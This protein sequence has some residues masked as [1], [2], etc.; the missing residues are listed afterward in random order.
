MKSLRSSKTFLSITLLLGAG[1]LAWGSWQLL[2]DG[3]EQ[4]TND[5]FVHADFTLVAPKVPGFVRE[6]QV[7][8]NQVVKAGQLLARIDDRDYRTA[9]ASARAEVASAE[10]QLANA[11]A[12]LERQQSQIGRAH[13]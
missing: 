9:L 1:L 8:D 12:T 2:A 7:E 11:H 6:V 5:A 13:V 10:A 4:Y 3:P